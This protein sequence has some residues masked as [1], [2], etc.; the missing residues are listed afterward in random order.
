MY[1][2]IYIY[3]FTCIC[4][5]THSHTCVCICLTFNRKNYDDF[6]NNHNSINNENSNDNQFISKFN[7]PIH[8]CALMYNNECESCWICY[9][10]KLLFSSFRAL[11]I[12]RDGSLGCSLEL[13]PD[14][15]GQDKFDSNREH[16]AITFCWK[17]TIFLSF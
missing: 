4:I 7:Y 9:I 13:A 17:Q 14:C 16:F 5:Y 8:S 1:I 12:S 11:F 6:V 3:I 15:S 2:Y 10:E